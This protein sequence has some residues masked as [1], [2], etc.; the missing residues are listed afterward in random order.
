MKN[1]FYI[2]SHITYFVAKAIIKKLGINNED[3]VMVISRSYTNIEI[4]DFNTI[5]LTIIHD[6]LD[7]FGLSNFY[8]K[9]KYINEIDILINSC[10]FNQ[11]F[12]AY[13]PHVFHPAMQIIASHKCCE[14]LHII[15]EGINAYSKY[16]MHNKEEHLIKTLIKR[17]INFIPII[18][19]KRI[20]FIKTFDLEKFKKEV[21]PTFFT[22]TSKGF[23]GVSTKVEKI[24]MLPLNGLNYDISGNSILVLEGAVEQGNMKLSTMLRGVE[25][26][27]N[28]I[29]VNRRLYIKYHPAQSLENR[30]KIESIIEHRGFEIVKI[31]NDIPFEQIILTNSDLNVYGF[32]TS[33]LFYAHEYGSKVYSYEEFLKDDLLFTRFREKNDFDLK[34]LLNG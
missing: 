9:H 4:H 2:H 29:N 8:K 25:R 28:E 11:R 15:E 26:I 23:K 6:Q 18:G 32:T 20:F 3:I 30:M 21:S 27:I 33:L 7:S 1:L 22:V 14:E 24:E 31:P 19:K 34:A 16:L 17:T 12:V 13:L 5:D 10:L